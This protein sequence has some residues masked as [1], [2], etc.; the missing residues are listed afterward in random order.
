MFCFIII[1]VV[2]QIESV[3]EAIDVERCG[4]ISINDFIAACL[5]KKQI[6]LNHIRAAFERL[7]NGM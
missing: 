7:D 1:I 6:N 5:A 3:F 2:V 4:C